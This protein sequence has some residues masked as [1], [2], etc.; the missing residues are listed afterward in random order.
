MHWITLGRQVL[1]E[2]SSL[3]W[4][5]LIFKISV[6]LLT[7]GRDA[8][9]RLRSY[10]WVQGTILA[11]W[12]ADSLVISVLFL[13]VACHFYLDCVTMWSKKQQMKIVGWQDWTLAVLQTGQ[14]CSICPQKFV[15]LMNDARPHPPLLRSSQTRNVI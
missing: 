8:T 6:F 4:N 10:K 3:I 2:V 9:A 12:S 13:L 11:S 5:L 15:S 1:F 7:E 14:V